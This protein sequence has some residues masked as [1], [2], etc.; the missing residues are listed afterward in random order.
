MPAKLVDDVDAP[1]A[2]PRLLDR[3]RCT[4]CELAT[5][6]GTTI[7]SPPPP[8][9][10]DGERDLLDSC[11]P[12]CDQRRRCAPAAPNAIA[13]SR[14]MPTRRSTT[15]LPR[16]CSEPCHAF[17]SSS[18]RA[19]LPRRDATHFPSRERHPR[20]G[21]ERGCPSPTWFS[22]PQLRGVAH[23]FSLSRHAAAGGNRGACAAW[24]TGCAWRRSRAG[25]R[26]SELRATCSSKALPFIDA[27]F[28]TTADDVD[29]R[30]PRGGELHTAGR[31]FTMALIVFGVG[32]TL[33]LLTIVAETLLE[34][35]TCRTLGRARMQRTSTNVRPSSSCG[36]C[37]T[38]LDASGVRG[39]RRQ[40]VERVVID[41]TRPSRTKAARRGRSSSAPRRPDEVLER[42]GIS[43][44][45][46]HRD[47]VGSRQRLRHAVG[48]REK[49]PRGAASA[50]G[51]TEAGSGA[52]VFPRRRRSGDLGLS[53]GGMRVAA[54]IL[55]PPVVDFEISDAGPRRDHRP[56]GELSTRELASRARPIEVP[57]RARTRARSPSKP[58]GGS[59]RL[60]PEAGTKSPRATC[61]S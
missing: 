53:D 35:G 7:G 49:N 18:H 52:C 21:A 46:R 16:K 37:W 42:A 20:P 19:S 28:M 58:E 41:S 51:E 56:R 9:S 14:P 8:P 4:A 45:D 60:I 10:R 33:Y 11:V 31:V 17:R 50:R 39:A 32:T 3:L 2:L 1:E 22:E 5:S 40:S 44:R 13:V 57:E 24:R 36:G 34:V 30:L 48:A 15:T 12:P 25:G 6:A 38:L 54:S 43:A 47:A 55:R 27:I 23:S 59:I 26:R 61:W 29:G